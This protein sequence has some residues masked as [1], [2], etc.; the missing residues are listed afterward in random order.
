MRYYHPMNRTGVHPDEWSAEIAVI[1]GGLG[2][3]AAALAALRAGR[4]VILTEE[5][6]WLGGQL[7]NQ[8]VP[9]DEHPWVEA[10]GRTRSY[11]DLRDRI[12]DYY[13]RTYPLHA[14]ARQDARLNPGQGQVSALCHEPRVALSVIQ[15]ML[16]PYEAD[17]QLVVLSE[18]RPVGVVNHGDRIESVTLEN[19][20]T[21]QRVAV[22]APYFID[23]TEL[24]DLLK[25][26]GVEHVIG[27]ESRADTGELHA[28]DGP[29]APQDQQAFSWCFAIDYL[30]GQDHTVDRPAGYQFWRDYQPEFWPGSLFSWTDVH[31]VT[32]A[33]RTEPIFAAPDSPRGGVHRDRWNFRR[34]M[35]VGQYPPGRYTSDVTTVNWPQIDYWGGAL[36]GVSDAERDKNLQAS[37]EQALSF[38]YWMQT[39]APTLDGGAGYPGLRLRPDVSGTPDGL[40]MR[41]Y[42]RES[43]RI[44][45]ETRIVEEHVGVLARAQ[46][47]LAEGAEHYHDSVG[48]GSYRIDLHPSTGRGG[49]PRTY[50]DVSSFPF[51]IPFGA[52]IPQRVDNLLAGGKNIGSTHITNGCYRLHPVEWNIGEAAGAAAA[53]ALQHHIAPRGIRAN[54]RLLRDFQRVLVNQ[55]GIGLEWPDWA[56]TIRN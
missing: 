17:R 25:L 49:T 12:R 29:A 3:V 21:G 51:E 18:H 30:P 35:S 32:L 14:D 26:G 31:P 24:G 39:E 4:R 38:L 40:A 52:M 56:R 11:A 10:I 28:V 36:L 7:T 8:M 45:A 19:R 34:I 46:A 23:A 42:I 48:V 33:P 43:R 41:A 53:Y 16:A 44:V 37:R 55:Y 50:V 2:G 6:A 1:G 15:E 27:S 20:C 54:P 9:P 13:R 22:S 5:S 47:G